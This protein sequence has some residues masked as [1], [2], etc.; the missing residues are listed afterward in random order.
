MTS[1]S[2]TH[3]TH[4]ADALPFGSG[5]RAIGLL[6]ESLSG[7]YQSGVW[8]GLFDA[9]RENGADLLC[10]CGGALGSSPQDPWEYQRNILYDFA[11]ESDLDGYIIV[12]SIGS[13]LS[14]GDFDAFLRRFG[15]KPILTIAPA[16]GLAPAV[17]ID[18]RA[19]IEEL[20]LHCVRRHRHRRFAFIKGPEASV[21]AQERFRLF[22]ELVR[23][24]GL[25]L[26]KDAVLPGS[27]TRES[28]A[29]AAAELLARGLDVDVIVAA[30]DDSALGALDTLRE[31]G[32][33]VPRDVALVGFDDIE[34]SS[35]VTPS[36]TTVAQSM[37]GLGKTALETIL[38]MVQG[39][40]VPRETL[41]DARLIIRQSCGCFGYELSPLPARRAI[42]TRRFRALRPR[43]MIAEL[44]NQTG[45]FDPSDAAYLIESF[46]AG[47]SSHR[48]GPFLGAV[49][50]V[51]RRTVGKGDAPAGFEGFL[52]SMGRY[53]SR[54]LDAAH[55]PFACALFHEASIIIGE[56]AS[57]HQR[58]RFVTL[59]RNT[60]LA[61]TVGEIIANALDTDSLFRLIVKHFPSLGVTDFFISLYEPGTSRDNRSRV[62]C[63]CIGGT[64]RAVKAEGAFDPR[65]L[66]SRRSSR[67][68]EPSVYITYSLHFQN[69]RF[70]YV[71]FM[72]RSSRDLLFEELP[73]YIG[74]SLNSSLLIAKIRNQTG[75]LRKTNRELV[76]L[77][78]KEREY[79]ESVQYELEL[80]R[81]IQLGFLPTRIPQPPG[82]VIAADF[83]P[84]REVSGDL[85]DVFVLDRTT[86]AFA[87]AD[88]S[89]K[90]VG[91]A[92]FMSLISTLLRTLA[93]RAFAEKRD[94]FEALEA[95][96]SYL[97]RYQDSD[98]SVRMFATMFFGL[99]NPETGFLTYINAGHIPPCLVKNRDTIGQLPPTG[100]ALGLLN[101]DVFRRNTVPLE[102]G[103][104]V[105]LYTDGVIDA[106]NTAGEFFS[107]KRII[108]VVTS[109]P[110]SA[111]G[112]IESLQRALREHTGDGDARQSDDITILALER[113]VCGPAAGVSVQ[114]PGLA[115]GAESA[116]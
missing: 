73:P 108:D 69:T 13:Y 89:G 12:G 37:Y 17:Y 10:Y 103:T 74:I 90:D 27:F 43:D 82:W 66:L 44:A 33:E 42:V 25:E 4:K 55:L 26:A 21:E 2:N 72:A 24:H 113:K 112:I 94:P 22:S 99:L 56:L 1:S 36:L 6:T 38:R 53:I 47:I 49:D 63:A 41:L 40:A 18:N 58:R 104:V 84:A 64:R 107:K 67:T 50:S 96:N 3:H 59:S 83:K 30:N 34:E 31:H 86:L 16:S 70:G 106:R 80:G 51:G 71:T 102:P 95:V 116:S 39:E 8:P 77:R 81:K 9:A 54:Y 28:G 100:P 46:C 48:R 35:S 75:V 78:E 91:A 65:E 93:Q 61:R 85:Y 68:T 57:R 115:Q 109:T 7:A 11:R 19:G 29:H 32:V 60:G 92:L 45:N 79:L 23:K 62:V 97:I 110:T 20:F 52:S 5:R 14:R 88:V 15:G 98:T 76:L 101:A 111:P 105:L 114:E 87:V